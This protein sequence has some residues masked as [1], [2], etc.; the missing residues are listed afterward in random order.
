M[1]KRDLRSPEQR[2]ADARQ[3]Y[4]DMVEKHMTQPVTYRAMI[5]AIESV[6]NDYA[7]DRNHDS[8]LIA[9]AFDKLIFQLSLV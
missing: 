4:A 1:S 8:D 7:A 5:E 6:R 9:N 2:E 3:A